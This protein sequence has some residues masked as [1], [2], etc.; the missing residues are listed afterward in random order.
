LFV[1]A[2]SVLSLLTL[3][4]MS[5]QHHLLDT[6]WILIL[7]LVLTLIPSLWAMANADEKRPAATAPLNLR[8]FL[9]PLWTGDFGWATFTRFLNTSALFTTITFL[10]FRFRTLSWVTVDTS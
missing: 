1:P 9:A 5:K 3:L 10:F 8:K 4:V 6:Y 7:V 2:G